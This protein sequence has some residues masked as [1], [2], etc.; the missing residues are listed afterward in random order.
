MSKRDP[1]R[2]CVL[3]AIGLSLLAGCQAGEESLYR[4]LDSASV[5]VLV[6]GRV[7]GE[8]PRAGGGQPVSLHVG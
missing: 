2:W 3:L 8:S 4:T 1:A 6:G 5:T 7:L